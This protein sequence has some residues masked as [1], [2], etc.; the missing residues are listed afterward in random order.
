MFQKTVTIENNREVTIDYFPFTI[1][2]D[3]EK[4]LDEHEAYQAFLIAQLSYYASIL[5]APTLYALDLYNRNNLDWKHS[6]F[7]PV[8][9][10]LGTIASLPLLALGTLIENY[11]I[12]LAE[13]Q[14]QYYRSPKVQHHS[15]DKNKPIG[16]GTYNIAMLPNFLCNDSRLDEAENRLPFII[17]S[18]RDAA[19]K[20]AVV[21]MQ[22][23]FLHQEKLIAGLEDLYPFCLHNIAPD[24]LFLKNS[25]LM[26]FS[27]IPIIE[28]YYF[29]PPLPLV[30]PVDDDNEYSHILPDGLST[31]GVVM[32]YLA[33]GDIVING[34]FPSNASTDPK[35]Q[36]VIER[37][38]RYA[39]MMTIIESHRFADKLKKEGKNPQRI[40]FCGDTNSPWE[41]ETGQITLQRQKNAFFFKHFSNSRNE[42]QHVSAHNTWNGGYGGYHFDKKRK[43]AFDYVNER[44]L[45]PVEQTHKK[46]T[47][48]ANDP[49]YPKGHV[50]DHKYSYRY[51]DGQT[52]NISPT[53]S[54]GSRPQ[55]SSVDSQLGLFKLNY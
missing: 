37:Y 40:I 28:G 46:V 5:K 2:D 9:G 25:G 8:L 13:K 1:P 43:V 6:I 42:S 52:S 30:T 22:E 51:P 53:A 12:A 38:R 4:T 10:V 29:R 7:N 3:S 27:K 33:N 18:V 19:D 11:S 34:H 20:V 55:N 48:I 45:V 41:E 21:C 31:K 49:P 44:L 16:Y 54:P 15:I 26:I 50:S 23:A 39:M 17:K 47:E 24:P 36:A 35:K 32:V 14:I